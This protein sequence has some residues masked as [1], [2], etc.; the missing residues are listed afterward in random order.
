MVWWPFATKLETAD[1]LEAI[2]LIHARAV[3][4]PDCGERLVTGV[5]TAREARKILENE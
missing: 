1:T 2:D 5:P 4:L 3:F